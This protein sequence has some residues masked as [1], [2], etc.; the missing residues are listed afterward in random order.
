[1]LHHQNHCF[2]CGSTLGQ[3]SQAT[4]HLVNAIYYCKKCRVD[5]CDQCSYEKQING[6][7]KQLCSRCDT[8][9]KRED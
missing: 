9:L 2:F 8:V 3:I 4:E 1:M 5:Y 7:S 6:K